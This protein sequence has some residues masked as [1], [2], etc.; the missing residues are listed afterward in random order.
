MPKVKR[1]ILQPRYL[2][3]F[4]CIGSACGDSC[5]EGW[6]VSVDKKTYLKYRHAADAE[7]APLFDKHIKRVRDGKLKSDASYAKVGMVGGKCPFLNGENLCSV[8]AALGHDYLSDVCAIYPR[9]YKMADK[10]LERCGTTSCP[11]IARLALSDEGG[12]GFETVEESAEVGRIPARA[13]AFDSQQ[14]KFAARPAKFFWDI[15]MFCLTFL[16]NRGYTLGQRLII[17]GIL[18]K[19]IDE[20]DKAGNVEGIPAVL[21]NFGSAIEDGALRP[22]LDK[23]E[24]NFLIQ[25]RIAKELTDKRLGMGLVANKKYLQCVMETLVGLD[26]VEGLPADAPLKKYI[27]NREIYV[28]AYMREKGYV[29]ENFVINEFFMRQMPFGAFE[30]VLDSYL[31]LCVTYGMVKLHINGMSGCHKKLDDAMVFRLIQA[32]SKVVLHNQK[33]IPNMIQL[34]KESGLDSQVWMAI[35]VND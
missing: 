16:Q 17:L 8:Q 26:I 6:S 5:C 15:R 2:S 33:F 19:K 7:L 32:F 1:V 13:S 14:V 22:E 10:K 34:L 31:Y 12:I 29:L 35:L 3:G 28:S 20:L 30:S 21:E 27:S 4:S 11:E 9:L 25:L 23:V 18:Y 24:N